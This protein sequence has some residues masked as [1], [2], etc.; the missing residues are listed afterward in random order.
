MIKILIKL[1]LPKTN[2]RYLLFDVSHAVNLK[3][4]FENNQAYEKFKYD[5]L[6]NLSI[7]TKIGKKS[8][9]IFKFGI[10]MHRENS[11]Y[12]FFLLFF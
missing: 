10:K 4:D 1:I 9:S 8:N 5:L 2:I 6:A 11:F 3:C 12:L 7:H